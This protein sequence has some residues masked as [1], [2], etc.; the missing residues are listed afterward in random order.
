MIYDLTFTNAWKLSGAPTAMTIL[1]LF[2]SA[3]VMVP[4]VRTHRLKRRGKLPP[5]NSPREG[6][7]LMDDVEQST[8]TTVYAPE[9][10]PR[11][12]LQPSQV[13]APRLPS[14]VASRAGIT[15]C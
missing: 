1:S 15:A 7:Y 9:D 13:Q 12:Q 14:P 4:I 5:R 6:W 10:R 3:A 2:A 11:S 8:K